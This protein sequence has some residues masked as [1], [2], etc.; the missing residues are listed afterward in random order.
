MIENLDHIKIVVSDLESGKKVFLLGLRE[1][2]TSE[3]SGDWIFSI[4][5]LREVRGRYGVF[6]RRI[7]Y[8]Y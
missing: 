2:Q 5:R 1:G 4:A 3:L 8:H 6:S 7:K